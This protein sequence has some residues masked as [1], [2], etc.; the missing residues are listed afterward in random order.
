M[1]RRR[2]L[3]TASAAALGMIA[4]NACRNN[5]PDTVHTSKSSTVALAHATSYDR[6]TIRDAVQSML[7]DLGGLSDLIKSGDKVGIKVNLTGGHR[8]AADFQEQT[9][10]HPG[11]TFWTHPE[12]LR[13]VG[14]LV[15]DAGAGSVYVVE[16]L[17]DEESL[18]M[19]G[20]DEVSDYLGATFVDLNQTDPY[21]GYATRPVGDNAFIYDTLTMNGILFDFDCFISLAKAK[22]HNS[23]G[24]THGMKNLIGNMPIPAGLY[25][26]GEWNRMAIHQLNGLD[27]NRYNNLCRLI[28]DLV[29]ATPIHLVVTDAVGT[30]LGGEGPWGQLTPTWMNTLVAGK[31][32]IAADAIAT[33]VIGLDP[34][35]ADMSDTFPN[36]IN[37]LKLAGDLGLGQYHPDNIDVV[38]RQPW[39][40]A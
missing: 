2:F 26:D 5:T 10:Q 11:E 33:K 25:N 37:Y 22:I 9:G 4:G 34:L 31:D 39:L 24:V 3:S 29:Q 28:V 18:S 16:A 14:E 7:D 8:Y 12:V 35:A 19:Y 20:F 6:T 21:G 17:A 40:F 1:N 30:V 38:D 27:G 15:K 36:C 32:P 23:T 13:A